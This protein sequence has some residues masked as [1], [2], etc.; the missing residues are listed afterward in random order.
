M[1]VFLFK[2]YNQMSARSTCIIDCLLIRLAYLNVVFAERRAEAP[3]EAPVTEAVAAALSE[4]R[5]WESLDW[6][7]GLRTY[8]S[9]LAG[10]MSNRVPLTTLE[11]TSAPVLPSPSKATTGINLRKNP[12]PSVP[13]TSLRT[14]SH[15][16]P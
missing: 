2:L 6:F 11:K 5:Q 12:Q 10:E 9:P 4:S 14:P 1:N 7:S 3:A 15:P 16:I 8:C 13:S